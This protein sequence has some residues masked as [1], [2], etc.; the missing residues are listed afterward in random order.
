MTSSR[1]EI[2]YPDSLRARLHALMPPFSA[3]PPPSAV[4][5]A[6][7]AAAAATSA[8]APPSRKRTIDA[9]SP[10]VS[11]LLSYTASTSSTTGLDAFRIG[12]NSVNVTNGSAHAHASESL[13]SR[14]APSATYPARAP[15]STSASASTE[16]IRSVVRGLEH[17]ARCDPVTGCGN[18][19]CVSTR[20]FMQKV[21]THLVAMSSKPNHVAAKCGACQLW[22]SIV[23][24][25]SNICMEANCSIPLCATTHSEQT[26]A[27]S[28]TKRRRG[29]MEQLAFRQRL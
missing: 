8:S 4:S 17:V 2:V 7:A 27:E 12:P 28:S 16:K 24:A 23:K 18:P 21:K 13:R 3:P 15:T 11:P 14:P 6:S 19:L 10:L 22:L 25:H 29:E 20:T 26:S 1:N 9:M 5:V